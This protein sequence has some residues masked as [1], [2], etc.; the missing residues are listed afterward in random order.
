MPELSLDFF[1]MIIAALLTIMILS[2]VIADNVL[3]RIAVYVFIGVASG[4]AGAIAWHNVIRPALIDPILDNGFSALFTAEAVGT[5][6]IPL[7]LSIIL[8]LKLSRTT[9]R[10]G[11]LS[12]AILVGVG[13]A[14]IVGGAITGTLIPQSLATSNALGPEVAFPSEGEDVFSWLE[15]LI[16]AIVLIVS[17]ITTLLYF[18]FSAQKERSGEAR[19]SRFNAALAYV[20]RTFIA[21]T[22]GVM[23]AGALMAAV[24]VLVQRFEFLGSLFRMLAGGG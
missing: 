16:G 8:M 5:Y 3:F 1:G 12:V 17:T 23:Y 6:L 2:Y 15:R 9:A 10:F 18:R 11:T 14:V 13:A 19:R 7:L 21:L 20:G 4:Y 22:F 24:L